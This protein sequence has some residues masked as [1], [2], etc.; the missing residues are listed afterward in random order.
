T[1]LENN[2]KIPL[3]SV[4]VR[5][6]LI[7][8]GLNALKDTGGVGVGAGGSQAILRKSSISKVA[9]IGSMHNFWVEILVEGGVCFAALFAL[10]YGSFIWRLS[11]IGRNSTDPM[12]QYCGKALAVAF[13]GFLVGAQGP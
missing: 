8:D 9:E 3:N 11:R 12:L 5:A 4:D 2:L 6:A 7:V 13:I 1:V 10:W